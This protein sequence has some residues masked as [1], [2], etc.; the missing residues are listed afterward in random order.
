MHQRTKHKP[1][2]LKLTCRGMPKQHF[3]LIRNSVVSVNLLI[4]QH[5][6]TPKP[7]LQERKEVLGHFLKNILDYMHIFPSPYIHFGRRQAPKGNWDKCPDTKK[8]Q[9]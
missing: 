8:L 6:F 5:G 3:P 1:S 2:F 4:P 7:I 9:Q